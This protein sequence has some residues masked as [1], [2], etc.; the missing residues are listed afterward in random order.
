M[1]NFFPLSALASVNELA[2]FNLL[3]PDR[4]DLFWQYMKWVL[5]FGAPIIMI[6]M[7]IFYSEL[8]VSVLLSIFP[9][10]K[11]KRDDDEN[12]IRYI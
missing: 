8:L 4:L 10:G 5:F 1:I 7:A 3:D 12:D 6:I 11:R 2:Y 9:F